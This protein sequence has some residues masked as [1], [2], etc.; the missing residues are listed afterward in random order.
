MINPLSNP[1]Y[2]LPPL[3]AA[4]VIVGLLVLVWRKSAR[5]FSSRLFFCLLLSLGL[6]SL[7]TFGM[8]SSP[9]VHH[10]LLWEKALVVAGIPVFVL[11]YHFTLTYTNIRRKR[12]I[13]AAIYSFLVVFVV[14]FG[15][16]D[17]AIKGMSLEHYGYAPI[18]GPIGF[19]VFAP[20]PLL[21]AGGAYNLLASCRSSSSY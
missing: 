14:L 8:R 21:V 9:D 10:A 17:L 5:N 15:T 7:L 13:V 11:Y 18:V 19:L 12:W 16:T 2:L 6:W 1:F 4:S 20:I 3:I